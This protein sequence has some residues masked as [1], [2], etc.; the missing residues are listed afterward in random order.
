MTQYNNI[1]NVHLILL[2][3]VTSTVLAHRL[4]EFFLKTSVVFEG[5]MEN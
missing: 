2:A 5:D 4:I 1:Y 3:S